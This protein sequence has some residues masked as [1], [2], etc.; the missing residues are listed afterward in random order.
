ML[1]GS[2]EKAHRGQLRKSGDLYITH[3][4]AVTEILAEYGLDQITLIAGLLHDTVEDTKL[5]L[6]QIEKQ[7][8]S[9]VALLIDGVTKLDRIQYSSPQEAQAATIRKMVVAMAADVRVLLLKLADRLHNIRTVA[10]L[11][12]E[13]QQRV[14]L[15]TI[16]V[17]VPLAHRLG[18]QEI[19]HEL[20]DRC[21]AILEPGIY[22]EIQDKLD[23]RAPER[24]MFIEKVIADLEADL[25]EAAIPA[26]VTGRP[27]HQY[28][29][30]R[31]MVE[32]QRGFEEIYDLIGIRIIT[33]DLRNC[34]AALGPGPFEVGSGIG[35]VQGLHRHAQ[36]QSLSEPP[37]HGHRP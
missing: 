3:P 36:D 32:S 22:A 25:A 4:V 29:I 27:K 21:F 18:V 23:D 15:E 34:Y 14:A 19:K 33:N 9:E 16:D 5:T 28:S 8:G 31:K 7:F 11:R 10:A 13:K 26:E 6:A 17:Y 12:L 24:E 1:T 20:E 30:Y 35:P 37:H 2:A